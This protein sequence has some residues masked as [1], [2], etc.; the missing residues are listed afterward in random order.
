[1]LSLF[2]IS[3]VRH[4]KP[5]NRPRIFSNIVLASQNGADDQSGT[6]DVKTTLIA[7]LDNQREIAI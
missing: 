3:A 2:S 6:N 1:M 4:S 5:E 7:N